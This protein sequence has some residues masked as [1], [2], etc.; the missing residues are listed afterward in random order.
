M[1]FKNFKCARRNLQIQIISL[2]K[3]VKHWHQFYTMSFKK[4]KREEYLSIHFIKLLLPWHQNQRNTIKKTSDQYLSSVQSLSHVQLFVTPWTAVLQASPSI[5]NSRSD[6]T[7]LKKNIHKIKW[8]LLQG[9]KVGRIFKN[10]C[11][12]ILW[13]YQLIRETIFDKVSNL[14]MIKKKNLSDKKEEWEIST[15]W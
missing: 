8:G 6:W 4:Q 2:K 5:T 13:S 10:Q 1:E 3:A 15:T 12:K 7:E 11:R 14:F 9:Y